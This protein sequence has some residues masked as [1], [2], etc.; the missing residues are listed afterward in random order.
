[1]VSERFVNVY[2]GSDWVLGL[3]YRQEQWECMNVWINGTVELGAREKVG[4]NTQWLFL[5]LA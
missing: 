3:L 2:H 1:M 5:S 4:M